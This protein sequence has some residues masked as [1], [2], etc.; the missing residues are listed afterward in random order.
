MRFLTAAV[1][2]VTIA[3]SS[4]G[5]P[6]TAQPEGDFRL[7]LSQ[8]AISLDPVVTSDN[9]SIWAQLLLYDTLVRPSA[10]GTELGPGLAESWTASDDG[11][12]YT[13]KL[14]DAKFADGTPVTA[15]DVV[16]SLKRAAGEGSNWSRFFSPITGFETPD[17]RTVILKLDE[18]FTPIINNL[19]MFSGAILPKK[20]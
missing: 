11:L 4:L 16:F 3:L 18:P 1:A 14:R 20:L 19:A 8:D 9:P 2:A 17:D 5:A 12:T 6:A 15:E 10:D 7:A 13:F